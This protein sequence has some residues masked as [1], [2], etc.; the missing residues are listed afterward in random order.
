V[1]ERLKEHVKDSDSWVTVMAG[2][3]IN[4]APGSFVLFWSG[5]GQPFL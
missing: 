1:S 2:I 5:V 4:G 3:T